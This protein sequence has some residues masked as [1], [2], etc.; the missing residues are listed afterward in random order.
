MTTLDFCLESLD[1][2]LLDISNAK[3]AKQVKCI[4]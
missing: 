2:L 3:N 1:L 4:S